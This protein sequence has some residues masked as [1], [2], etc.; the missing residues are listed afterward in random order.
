MIFN[1]EEKQILAMYDKGSVRNTFERLADVYID[2]C[3]YGEEPILE[4]IVFSALQKL[5]YMEEKEY[6]RMI[7]DIDRPVGI[8]PGVGSEKQSL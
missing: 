3:S 8:W 6:G 2:I 1:V 7:K 5:S 4:K